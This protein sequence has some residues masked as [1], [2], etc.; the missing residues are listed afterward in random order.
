MSEPSPSSADKQLPTPLARALEQNE[1]VLNSVEQSATELVVINAVLKKEI[2]DPVKI[3]D[4]A[5]ALQ[6]TD[7]LEAKINETAQELA[8]V[9]EVL[10]QEV[11]E[12]ADLER[13]LA[14]TK[15]ALAREKTKT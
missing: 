4:V 9:N 10:E 1:I 8:Q 11:D 7:E 14:A 12:R 15:A 3:G 13:E 5:Q 2:P 6:K